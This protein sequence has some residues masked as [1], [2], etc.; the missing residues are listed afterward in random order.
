MKKFLLLLLVIIIA[1]A[2]TLFVLKGQDNYDPSKYRVALSDGLKIGSTINYTLPDQFDKSNTL[3]ENTQKIIIVFTK[4]AG[5]IVKEFLH[6]QSADYLAKHKATFVADVSPMP[7]VIRNTFALPDLKKQH[8]DVS[9][10]YDKKIS[11]LLKKDI[12]TQ[13]ITLLHIDNKKITSLKNIQKINVLE[14]ALR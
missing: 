7:V 12:D 2:G 11:N 14:E 10:I 9:L 8:Y 3:D 5:H 4:K 6:K 1:G 13:N